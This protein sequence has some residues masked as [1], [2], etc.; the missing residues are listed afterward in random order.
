KG[1]NHY[2]EIAA[3]YGI[4]VAYHHHMGTGVQTKEET[5]R[6]MENT[7]P[8]LVG[9]LYDTGHISVSDGEYLP[10]LKAHIDRIV[11]VHFKDVRKDKEKD[12]RQRGLTFQGSFLNGMFT[13][14]GD[15]NLDFKPVFK[16]L[17]EHNYKGWIVVE[18][19]QDPEKANPLEMAQKAH[20]YIEN[21]LLN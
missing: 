3:K 7:D 8:K 18:A 17:L 21:E 19:E 16:E 20:R 10:L 12:S 5:D 9:L 11:H 14:P 2:G 4:K 13:V 6:L 1:L 15:G